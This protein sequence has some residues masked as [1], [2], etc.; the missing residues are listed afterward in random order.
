MNSLTGLSGGIEE[1]RRS[2]APVAEHRFGKGRGQLLPRF[3]RAPL[4]PEAGSG[5]AP[6]TALI[7]VISSLAAL[8][9]AAFILI[10]VAAGQWTSDLKSSVTVQVKGSDIEEINARTEI[11]KGVL[12]GVSDVIGYEVINSDDAGKLLEPWLGKGNTNGLNVPALIELKITPAARTRITD[13]ARR[14]SEASPGL[15]LDDHSE[16][17]GRLAA[18]A[19]SGQALAF[20]IFCLIMGAASAIS[21]FAA[22]AGLAANSEVVALLHLVGATDS[23]IANEVQRRFTLIGLRGSALGTLAALFI[24]ALMALA[25]RTR[26]SDAGFLPRFAFGPELAVALLL[27]PLAIC[28]VTA[29][30]ARLTVLKTLGETY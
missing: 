8:S 19:R 5:G 11:A 21:I 18:A 4:F 13:L 20:A 27:V 3:S 29:V 2:D 15:V 7:A 6:L 24:L 26:G 14:L 16:W 30:A 23:F 12:S 17:N 10:A 22:R 1:T 9:L 25:T 28:L